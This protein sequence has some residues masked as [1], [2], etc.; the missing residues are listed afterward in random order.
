V[1]P[2]VTCPIAIELSPGSRRTV[3]PDDSVGGHRTVSATGDS[4]DSET[5]CCSRDGAVAETVLVSFCR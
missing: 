2:I 5:R 3:S 4:T 1:G